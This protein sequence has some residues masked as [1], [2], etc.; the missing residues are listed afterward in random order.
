MLLGEQGLLVAAA[1]PFGLA[2]GWL[3][4]L[5]MMVR[6]ESDLFRLP[7]VVNPGTYALATGMV[8]VS[9]ALSALLVWRRLHRMD[10]IAVL[11]TRE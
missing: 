10:L 1:I 7:V 2:L 6:F 8:L 3:L 5:V 11:K 9:A 4:T